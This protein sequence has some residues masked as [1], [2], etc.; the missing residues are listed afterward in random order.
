[1]PNTAITREQ[2]AVMIVKYTK[3]ANI[4]L[5][6]NSPQKVFTDANSI[7]PWAKDAVSTLQMSG[8]MEG[9]NG[10]RFNPKAKATRAEVCLI[11]QKLT[12]LIDK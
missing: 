1:M 6:S 12:M 5:G 3:H 10:N 7:S 2:L 11:M 9:Q 8:I 4:D